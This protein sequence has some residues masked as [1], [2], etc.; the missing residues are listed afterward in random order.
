MLGPAF[1]E[2]Q[3]DL[4]ETDPLILPDDEYGEF[5][6]FAKSLHL[7]TLEPDVSTMIG[8]AVVAGKYGCAPQAL[9]QLL[10]PVHL[11]FGPSSSVSITALEEMGM[12]VLD[13]AYLALLADDEALLWRASRWATVKLETNVLAELDLQERLSGVSGSD[14]CSTSTC[15]FLA[16]IAD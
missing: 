15:L 14:L 5:L 1:A 2:G 9:R 6:D 13:V 3:R 7:Q 16:M 11:A 8:V 10:A 4:D 12:S